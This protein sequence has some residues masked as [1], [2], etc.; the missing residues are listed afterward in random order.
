MPLLR[1]AGLTKTFTPSGAWRRK[2]SAK[3]AV[4]GLSL[5]V[6]PGEALGLV[7]ESGCGKSTAA[8]LILRLLEPDSGEIEL[9]GSDLRALDDEALRR[10]RARMQLIFQDP[11]SSLNPRLS[12][13]QIIEEPLLAHDVRS[14]LERDQ[15]IANAMSD[16]GLS[17]DMR[18]RFPH[19][20]SGGQ[21][22]RVGIARALVLRPRLVIADEPVSALDVSV[23][24]QVLNL[25]SDLQ[26]AHGLG[27][28]FVAHDIAVVEQVSD[29]IAVMYAG[30]IVEIGSAADV[31]REPLHPY[32][33]ALIAAV[34]SLDPR[35]R[36]SR[37]SI[38]RPPE[39]QASLGGC[40]YF[41][42]CAIR[43]Q[44]CHQAAPEPL[45]VSSTRIVSCHF[46]H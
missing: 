31:V 33:R 24:A 18:Q 20:F 14:K 19:E 34:P 23:Q 42:R 3:R 35:D 44:Q 26:Q 46:V 37:L 12:V 5:H 36:K 27:M 11:Y 1:V 28:I 38:E 15:R 39:E 21:R 45:R 2:G 30:R 7:G 4:D 6:E 8:R 41:A 25:L 17:P 10:S 13:N 9:D 29:R 40:P 16:V 43:K 22:Q 32:T